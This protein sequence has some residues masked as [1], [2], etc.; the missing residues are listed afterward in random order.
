MF[1]EI[2]LDN[3]PLVI[4]Q[5]KNGSG[6]STMLDA[7]CFV[8][9]GKP[10]RK[11]NK[12]T[13][14]NNKNKKDLV[15]EVEF[16]TG[17][18]LYKIRRGINPALFQVFKD[19][20]LVDQ[21]AASSDYQAYLENHILKYDYSTF[22]QLV[23]IGKAMYVSFLKL[24]SAKRRAFIENMLSLSIFG[25]MADVHKKRVSE[26]KDRLNNVQNALKITA[27]EINLRTTYLTDLESNFLQMKEAS[28]LRIELE[29]REAENT[30][31]E[32]VKEISE[33]QSSYVSVD[34]IKLQTANKTQ[35]QLNDF[36][37]KFKMRA[38]QL[39]KDAEFFEKH[40]NCPV[41][42]Q[43]IHEELKIEKTTSLKAKAKKAE[44]ALEKVLLDIGN[45]EQDIL[46]FMKLNDQNHAVN[47][48]CTILNESILASRRSI[49][50]LERK[51]VEEVPDRTKIDE[52][53][54]NLK[55]LKVRETEEQVERDLCQD[56]Q[57][58]Y[59]LITA[60]L[61]DTG[62]KSMVIKRF[63]PVFNEIA[64]KYL[65]QLGFFVK[66]V[67]DESFDEKIYARGIDE[68][69][70]YNYSEGEKLRI[71]LAILLTWREFG[72][73]QGNNLTNLIIFDEILDASLDQAGADNF[74]FLIGQ[75]QNSNIFLISHNESKWAEKQKPH[76]VFEKTGGFSKIKQ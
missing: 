3:Q 36:K 76:I 52:A 58:Y 1:T 5:G 30:I 44:A 72:K 9:F 38:S 23:I 22:T 63:I 39:Y 75:L 61:K 20:V 24:D 67:L 19:G 28:Q 34:P 33:L 37:S 41:C 46:V 70:Y 31:A 7:L 16:T 35:S 73:I 11:I 56:N 21:N 51:K 2:Q 43:S 17:G 50:S 60:M 65:R 42:S 66:L 48:R 57:R 29:I 64:N 49:K 18:S 53:I 12:P 32:Y 8:L 69:N 25:L 15:V 10:Y 47:Q 27:S 74:L 4:I 26:L 71:D 62:I 6:K 40:D 59:D 14:V 13:L 54:V 55:A 45:I 68:L